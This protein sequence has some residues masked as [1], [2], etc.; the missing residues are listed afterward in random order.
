MVDYLEDNHFQ[1]IYAAP[2][3][4]ISGIGDRIST[5]ISLVSSGKYSRMIEGL[6]R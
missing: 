4:K 2:P 3:E 1:V 6:V 5:T